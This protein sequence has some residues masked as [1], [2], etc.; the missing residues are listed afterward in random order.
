MSKSGL[1]F[2]VPL[3][4]FMPTFAQVS[5]A[6]DAGS[7]SLDEVVCKNFPPPTGT[8]I[9]IRRVCKTQRQWLAYEDALNRARIL[10]IDTQNNMGTTGAP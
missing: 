10:Q 1:V 8:R 6:A 7:P 5:A 3:L 4:C 9:G 2:L